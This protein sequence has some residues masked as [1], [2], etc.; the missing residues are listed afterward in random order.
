[1]LAI[2]ARWLAA[3]VAEAG[4]YTDGKYNPWHTNLIV[5]LGLLEF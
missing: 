1:M 4:I 3:D 2:G 5:I